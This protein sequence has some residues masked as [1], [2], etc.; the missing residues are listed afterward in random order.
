MTLRLVWLVLLCAPVWAAPKPGDV[1]RVEHRP[2]DALPTLGP[3]TAPVTIELFFAPVQSSRRPEFESVAS[4][5][6][7]TRA[8]S[9]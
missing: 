3:S 7:S 5:R 4:S 6:R 8:G 9:A 2:P 1:V